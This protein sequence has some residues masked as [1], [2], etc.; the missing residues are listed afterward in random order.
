M[1]YEVKV[2]KPL[3]NGFRFYS[4]YDSSNTAHLAGIGVRAG[5]IHAP[6]GLVGL[7][8]L[9]EHV[10]ARESLK[11][12][13][14]KIELM[15][16]ALGGPDGDINI[17]IDKIST[18]YGFASLLKKK[19]MLSYFDLMAD[20][21]KDKIVNQRGVATEKAAVKNEYF[22][23]GQDIMPELLDVLVHET[24]YD[25]N[26]ARSRVDCGL[27]D[28]AK[29]TPYHVR[30]F[31]KKHYVASN[32]FAVIMGPSF[33]EVKELVRRYFNDLPKCQPP[34][35]NYDHSD[36]YPSLTSIKS[37][38]VIRDVGQY[39]LAIAFPTENSNSSDREAIEMLADILSYR[40]YMRL[41]EENIAFDQGTYRAP[42]ETPHSH[43]HG[44]IYAWFATVSKEYSRFGEGVI[45]EEASKL[46]S[47]LVSQDEFDAA[48]IYLDDSYLDAFR[49]SPAILAEMVIEAICN[50]DAEL[51]GLHSFRNRLHKV[52]RRKLRDVANK[53]FTKNYVR[54][55]IGPN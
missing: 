34:I 40:L 22:L 32:M 27:E 3:A 53:Y 52:T 54:V 31:I 21:I 17:R 35:L 41:R 10:V 18:F 29:I 47:E 6:P 42:V 33:E 49:N 2:G 46:R 25:R 13:R 23:R 44:L 16:L 9:A 28:L 5:G 12:G 20:L 43:I 38:G 55:T 51:V 4:Q 19:E 36:D 14:E 50:G 7:P 26:P 30:K 11:Y 37:K 39:Y 1:R 48:R 8:H 24:A 45:L 15:T